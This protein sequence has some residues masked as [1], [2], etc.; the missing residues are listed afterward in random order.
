MSRDKADQNKNMNTMDHKKQPGKGPAIFAWLLTAAGAA[1]NVLVHTMRDTIIIETGIRTFRSIE[2]TALGGL[3]VL[4]LLALIVTVVTVFQNRSSRKAEEMALEA[5]AARQHELETIKRRAESPLAVSDRLDPP[6]LQSRVREAAASLSGE[7]QTV[8]TEIL[9][10]MQKMDEL[11]DKHLKLLKNNAAYA[12]NDTEE[13]LDQVEQYMCRNV[14]KILNYVDVLDMSSQQDRRT[15]LVH[16]KECEAHNGEQLQK[17]QEFLVALTEFLNQ[18]GEGKGGAEAL[19]MYKAT[20]L[21]AI[22]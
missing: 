17:T 1:G 8:M 10:Q 6:T 7:H 16:L 14:R 20:I 12:L 19:D 3:G 5:D 18:Q 22:R 13:I 11:Q 4:A 2:L 21:K 9:H 15:L